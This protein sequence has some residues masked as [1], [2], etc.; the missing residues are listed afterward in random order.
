MTQPTV[1]SQ[2]SSAISLIAIAAGVVG[3][4]LL[5]LSIGAIVA[6]VS[7]GEALEQPVQRMPPA[8]AATHDAAAHDNAV[9]KQPAHTDAPPGRNSPRD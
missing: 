5:V 9:E 1:S 3:F 2:T 4:A 6:M 8:P 7:L